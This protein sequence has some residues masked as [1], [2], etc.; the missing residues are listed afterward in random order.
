[1]IVCSIPSIESVCKPQWAAQEFFWP[2]IAKIANAHNVCAK[3][4]VFIH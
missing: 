2:P 1:M 3:A 4:I